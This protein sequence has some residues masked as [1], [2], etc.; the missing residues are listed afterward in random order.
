MV[1]SVIQILGGGTLMAGSWWTVAVRSALAMTLVPALILGLEA[2]TA[3]GRSEV[4]PDTQASGAIARTLQAVLVQGRHPYVQWSDFPAYRDPLWQLYQHVNFQLLWSPAGLPSAQ[5][6]AV[7][8]SLAAADTKGLQPADYDAVLLQ[9]RWQDLRTAPTIS[10]EDLALFDVAVSFSLMRYAS[11]LHHGRI[12]SQAVGFGLSLAPK[13]VEL[14]ALIATLGRSDNITATLARVEPPLRFYH[15]LL[16]ALAR[17]RALA[18]EPWLTLLPLTSIL[19]PGDRYEG[20]PALRRLLTA[21]GDLPE[22]ASAGHEDGLYSGQLVEAVKHFQ[23]RHGLNADGIIG[24]ATQAQLSVP[25][26]K[27]VEQIILAL[28]GV[29]WLPANPSGPYLVV[30]IPEFNLRVLD[31]QS[32][33]EPPRLVL[34]MKV[35]VGQALNARRTPVFAEAMR[36]LIFRPSWNVP[37][38]ITV[39]ELLPRLQRHPGYAAGEDLELVDA[40]GDGARVYPPTP[41]NVAKLRTGALKLRQRPGPRN[42]LGL[43]KFVLPNTSD[44]YLHGTPTPELFQKIRRDFSHGCIRVED[45]VALA[46][47]VLRDQPEWTQERIQ[48]AM[49]WPTPRRVDLRDP[50]PVYILYSTVVV[51]ESGEV[52]FFDDIYGHDATLQK[53]LHEGWPQGASTAR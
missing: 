46:A 51:K 20:T 33:G 10:P 13:A 25:F 47:F 30:N 5:A 49:Q 44:I 12:D 31:F 2:S 37:Y 28:E 1:A 11:A 43:V 29:R 26:A 42:A 9:H 18:Q 52:F 50:L 4:R 15:L 32:A 38:R 14:P 21:L 24:A 22:E 7:I 19:H 17:Y 45:P 41:A 48:Q 3:A 6:R 8:D 35:I 36:S 40:F 34:Q 27:R 16:G 39:K 53:L 23:R